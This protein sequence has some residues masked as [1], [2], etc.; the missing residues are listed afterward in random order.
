VNYRYKQ[1]LPLF[2]AS[3][4]TGRA[5]ACAVCSGASDSPMAQGMNWG[6]LTLLVVVTGVLGGIAAVAVFFARRSAL[7]AA[8][9][10]AETNLQP[11][12]KL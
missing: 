9:M 10:A 11:V 8:E 2:A 1:L 7:V 3:L 6:I 5:S 12:Q 4:A